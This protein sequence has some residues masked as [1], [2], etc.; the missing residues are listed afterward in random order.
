MAVQEQARLVPTIPA[1]WYHAPDI[2]A[3]ERREIFA[4]EWLYAAH[5][6]DLKLPGDYVATE[7]AGYSI[8]I[9]VGKDGVRRAF[10]NIC[11]H[12]GAPLFTGASG[13]IDSG[14][15]ACKYHGF[16]YGLDGEFHS[17]PY[18]KKEELDCAALRL[19][20]VGLGELHGM[21]F[22]NLSPEAKPFDAARAELLGD[23]AR[24]K[25]PFERYV[26]R[27]RVERTGRFNWKAWVDGYQ[28][29]YHCPTIHPVFNKDFNLR[30][31][32]VANR[33]GFSIHSCERKAGSASPS[34]AHEG[35]WLWVYPNLGLPCYEPCY[36]TLQVNPLGPG[37]TRLSYH[38]HFKEP[39]DAP[40]TK[41][42]LRFVEQVTDEDISICE[43]VQKNL[44]SGAY[45]A[46]LLNA[47][48][49]NGVAYFHSRVRR[50]LA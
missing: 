13:R 22:V 18:L 33:D 29:C 38:F 26:H 15:V 10:H 3:R 35:L 49:E 11:R 1:E 27:A 24:A 40:A 23:V 8:A 19:Q 30:E 47:E 14:A 50:A 9:V 36:Y 39:L 4:K 46:G 32:K 43:A 45:A 34:G 25:Y 31:Y 28:E 7:I 37:E 17:A 12:R 5:A 41:E 16:T 2:Y 21:L 42:F 44:E 6:D 20:R 48:R